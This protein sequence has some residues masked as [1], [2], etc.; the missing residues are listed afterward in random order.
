MIT[1]SSEVHSG[2]IR[3]GRE[4]GAMIRV[5]T[6]TPSRRALT[7]IRRGREE[8]AMIR[9]IS[10]IWKAKTHIFSRWLGGRMILA[11]SPCNRDSFFDS[12][13]AQGVQKVSVFAQN[14]PDMPKSK[15]WKA[16]NSYF[17]DVLDHLLEQKS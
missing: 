15:N 9:A 7:P 14:R 10:K 1:T 17:S 4:E 6:V 12:P 5:Y 2:S 11:E 16:K 3:R 13:K 8:G